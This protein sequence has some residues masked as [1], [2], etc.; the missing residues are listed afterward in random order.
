MIVSGKD[1]LCEVR[2]YCSPSVLVPCFCLLWVESSGMWIP[3]VMCRVSIHFCIV[4][5]PVHVGML[6]C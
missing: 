2:C 1:D 6:T 4:A 5:V 3:V